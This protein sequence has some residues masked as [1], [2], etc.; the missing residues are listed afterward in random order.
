MAATSWLQAEDPVVHQFEAQAQGG[1]Q[2]DEAEGRGLEL[3][4][5]FQGGVGGVVAGDGVQGAVRQALLDGGHVGRGPERRVDLG[6]G[7]VALDR[8]IRQGEVVG[9]GLGGDGEAR[10]LGRCGSGPRCR[11]R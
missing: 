1:F 11:R 3:Q 6:V 10:G 9:R 4:V 8:L 7:V 2:A 5:F